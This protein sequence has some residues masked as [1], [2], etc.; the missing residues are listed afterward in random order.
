VW[1]ST[2]RARLPRAALTDPATEL[3]HGS[4][5]GLTRLAAQA[6]AC[7]EAIERYCAS[8]HPNLPVVQTSAHA[9]GSQCI[10]PS[11]FALFA[12][13]QYATPGWHFRHV[14]PTTVL[15]WVAGWSWTHQ[16]SVYLPTC[17]V[18]QQPCAGA[19]QCLFHP[20]STGLACATTTETARLT[21]LCEVLERDAIMIAWLYGL[22]LP[23]LRP[24]LDDPVI[25]ELSQRITTTGLHATVLD[26]TM[27]D[28]G[29]PVRIA[30]VERRAGVSA[31][32]AVGMAAHPVALQ[33]HRKSLIEA[34]HTL[35]WLQHMQQY[36]PI[37]P[38]AGAA[39]PFYTF[40]EHVWHYGCAAATHALDMW[41]CGP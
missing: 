26:A 37:Q 19:G 18:Y 22:E 20:V 34:C 24:P 33:A 27:P 31:A 16:R 8:L 14:P 13:D 35:H 25:Q 36:A 39:G 30:L 7:G 40:K 5:C 6:A 15:D 10:A 9:L 17:F 12:E 32:C 23:R 28:I 21:G 3:I 29:L 2:V 41:R 4:G 1:V 11:R 38:T